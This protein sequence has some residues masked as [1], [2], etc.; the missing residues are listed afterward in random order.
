MK[1][2]KDKYRATWKGPGRDTEAKALADIKLLNTIL[3]EHAPELYAY[4]TSTHTKDR[5]VP[6]GEAIKQKS[7]G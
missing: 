7:R 2:L 5:P 1:M 6:G 3:S 4:A